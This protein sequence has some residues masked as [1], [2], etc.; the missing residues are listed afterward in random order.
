MPLRG[1]AVW[2]ICEGAW[3]AGGTRTLSLLDQLQIYRDA[4]VLI[5]AEGS[6]QHGLELLGVHP[7]KQDFE[8]RRPRAGYGSAAQSTFPRTTSRR[9]CN[10][11]WVEEGGVAWNGLA[12]L[13]WEH[14]APV[15]DRVLDEPL[16]GLS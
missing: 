14:V 5:V 4:Q 7:K 1:N 2:R 11:V 12:E 15:L 10:N 3:G 9:S 8:C 16:W 13:A 6:A